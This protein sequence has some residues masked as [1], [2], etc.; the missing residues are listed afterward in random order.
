MRPNQ[1]VRVLIAEDDAMVARLVRSELESVGLIVIGHAIDGRQAVDLTLALMPDVVVMDITMPE[2]DGI[3]AASAIQMGRPT[4]V[5]ILSAHDG[6]DFL[7]KATAAGVGA[8]V[9]KPPQANELERAITIAVARHDDLMELQSLNQ[10]LAQALAEIKTLKGLLPI[11]CSCKKIRD[12]QGYWS[13]VE[14]FIASHTDATFTHSYCPKCLHK[15][16]PEIVPAP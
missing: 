13:E 5:V 9:I 14:T 1:E 2:L 3:A 16:F 4:P 6:T 10:K 7:I 15:Y 8:F 12:D 11:C